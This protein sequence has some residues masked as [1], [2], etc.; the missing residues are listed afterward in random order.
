MY[1]VFSIARAA[2]PRPIDFLGE[3]RAL[4]G[5]QAG[6][7]V[8]YILMWRIQSLVAVSAIVSLANIFIG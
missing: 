6:A 7:I 8:L 1:T 3:K 5:L 4:L 2:A